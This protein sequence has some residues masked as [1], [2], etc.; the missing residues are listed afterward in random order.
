M[1]ARRRSRNTATGGELRR[2]GLAWERVIFV[3]LYGTARVR[4]DV[5]D[6]N[7]GHKMGR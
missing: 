6:T 4:E 1:S 3:F 5:P 2:Q 7:V